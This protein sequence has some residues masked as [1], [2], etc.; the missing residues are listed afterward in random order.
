MQIFR[1]YENLPPAARGAAVAIGNFDGVHRGHQA[2]IGRTKTLGD[3]LGVLVFE[4]HPQEFFRPTGER[5][6][7]TPFRAKARLLEHYG[8][9][10]A[11]APGDDAGRAACR[12][13][14]RR[15]AEWAATLLHGISSEHP[16]GK[17]ASR[18]PAH[19]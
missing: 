8:A 3:K 1:H 15:L 14:G 16:G 17:L 12:L 10:T 7:L 13:L 9:V 19:G 2:L 5:F 4:P 6:R 11:K 18:R